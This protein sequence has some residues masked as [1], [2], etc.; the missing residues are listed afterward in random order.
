MDKIY[1]KPLDDPEEVINIDDIELI[2]IIIGKSGFYFK[3]I[4]EKTGVNYIWFDNN[5]KKIFIWGD[6]EK[7]KKFHIYLSSIQGLFHL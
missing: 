2:P 4:T 3:N 1:I 5:C 7:T 6:K